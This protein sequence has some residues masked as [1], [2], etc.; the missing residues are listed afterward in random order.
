M[1]VTLARRDIKKQKEA[2]KQRQYEEQF[3]R[4][5]VTPSH[6]AKVT[7]R[8]DNQNRYQRR[9]QKLQQVYANQNS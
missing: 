2:E 5:R 7:R 9:E 6:G 1:A 3:P 8:R 4:K